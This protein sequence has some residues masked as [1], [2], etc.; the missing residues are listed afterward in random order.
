MI[1]KK[2]SHGLSDKGS[3]VVL[4]VITAIVLLIVAYAIELK[5]DL[6][7]EKKADRPVETLS[8]RKDSLHESS[9]SLRWNTREVRMGQ[10]P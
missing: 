6:P 10:R 4:V 1:K 5:T 3:D 2:T 9:L 7:A 8:D